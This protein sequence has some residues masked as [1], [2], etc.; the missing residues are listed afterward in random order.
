MTNHPTTPSPQP[1]PVQQIEFVDPGPAPAGSVTGSEASE[2]GGEPQV[3]TAVPETA[4]PVAP[5]RRLIWRL[6]PSSL[7]GRLVAGVVTLVIIVVVAIGIGTFYALRN[8]LDSRLDQQVAALSNG[9][10]GPV[11][12]CLDRYGTNCLISGAGYRTSEPAWLTVTTATGQGVLRIQTDDSLK[13]MQL[14]QQQ[15]QQL[16]K[17]PGVTKHL[18]TADGTELWVMLRPLNT[19]FGTVY[20]VTGLNTGDIDTTMHRL[21]LLEWVIG[22]CAVLVAMFATYG[23]IQ[24]SLRRLQR[25]SSTAHD[26]ARELSPT[27]RGLDQRVPLDERDATEVGQLAESMNLLLYAVETQFG[28]RLDSERRMRQFLA[29]ASHE[30]RTPL[31]SIRGYAE[32]ARMHR[33]SEA[34]ARGQA[35]DPNAEPTDLDR[36]EAEGTRMSRLVEDLLTLA[37]SDQAHEDGQQPQYQ[38]VDVDLLLDDVVSGARVAYPSRR[39]DLR[40]QPGLWLSGD[41]DQL[42]RAVR[43]LVNNAATHTR[44]DG[45]I[46]VT[47]QRGD[48]TVVIQV[49]DTGPGLPPEE[50]A[51]VFERFW[52]ADK[53]RTRVRGGSGLGM[54]IVESIVALHGGTIRFDSAVETG[55]TVTITLPEQ[56]SPLP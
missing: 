45:P 48:G 31:T 15:L 22:G 4:E 56:L 29:D 3:S 6:A 41:P 2:S 35:V 46:G 19:E 43:N 9:N 36:I 24:F 16:I 27:G 14:S 51:H 42:V 23:G 52:R 12:A 8:F 38:P 11:Q 26:V 25:V 50:A 37:R 40:T 1:L 20:M 7:T 54:S 44:P 28:A 18:R 17:Q 5:R 47:A 34:A 32:L 49:S 21:V 55:S 53:A 39:I 10:H 30:L 13:I 33:R